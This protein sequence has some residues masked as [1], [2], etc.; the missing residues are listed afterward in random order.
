MVR[1]VILEAGERAEV[2]FEVA[3]PEDSVNSQIP[4]VV[5]VGE[6]SKKWLLTVRAP[7]FT[8]TAR[9]DK[10]A[11]LEGETLEVEVAVASEEASGEYQVRVGFNDESR[12]EN[13]KLEGGKGRAVF[14]NIPVA[15][16][17]NRSLYGLYHPTGR[18]VRLTPLPVRDRSV[19]VLMLPDR[20][21]YNAGRR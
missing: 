7:V 6:K 9:T 16:R 12:V 5:R 13:I 21:Q 10:E 14:S 15:F 11:Y 1:E 18:S 3:M 19:A 20:Q 8:M 2:P 4:A 17:G